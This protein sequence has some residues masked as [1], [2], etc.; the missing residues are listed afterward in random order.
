MCD[1]GVSAELASRLI[2]DSAAF[3]IRW[4]PQVGQPVV[5]TKLVAQGS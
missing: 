2:E 1:C 4:S 3:L 5:E